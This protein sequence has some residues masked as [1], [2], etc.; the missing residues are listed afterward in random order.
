MSKTA[1]DASEHPA[2]AL[3]DGL[4]VDTLDHFGRPLRDHLVGTWKLLRDWGEP[5]HLCLAGLFHS[6]Y[7]T[8]TFTTATLPIS[9]R[10][11]IRAR[12]GDRAEEL[13]FVFCAADRRRLLL[14]NG[15]PPYRWIDHRTGRASAL[16]AGML[17]ELVTLD[18]ANFLEQLEAR[19]DLPRD[20][21]DD[22]RSRFVAAWAFLSDGAVRACRATFGDR[23]KADR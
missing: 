10:D 20:T 4:P 11:R 21:V 3:L 22:M 9:E 6:V 12:I 14:E 18:V 13:V 16:D 17:A 5:E 2:V 1:G 8:G 15:S 23:S 7:G 19:P